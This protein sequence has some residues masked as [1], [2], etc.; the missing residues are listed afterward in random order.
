MPWPGTYDATFP[1]FPYQDNVEYILGSYAN[2]WV[3]A[4]QALETGIGYGS[5]ASSTNPLY[6]TTFNETYSTI[7]ARIV[8]LEQPLANY[9]TTVVPVIDTAAGDIVD[10]GATRSAG[11]TG[12]TAD[13]G[14][15]HRGV[16]S[17]NGRQGAITVGTA[18]VSTPFTAAG[19]IVVGTGVGT[20][21]LLPIGSP[22][23]VLTVGG[24]DPSG[25]QWGASVWNSGDLRFTSSVVVGSG[26]LY[27]D[28]AAVSRASFGNLLA[29]TTISFAATGSGSTL[30]GVSP[31][32][33]ALLAIGMRIE[34]PGLGTSVTI[35][36]VTSVVTLSSPPS[37]GAGT[38]VAFPYGNGN[39]T[40][41]FNVIDMRGRTPVG[42][43]GPGG[44]TQPY[45]AMGAVGGEQ[46]HSLTA[47]ENGPHNHGVADPGHAHVSNAAAGVPPTAYQTVYT[48]PLA[49]TN[50]IGSSSQPGNVNVTFN[51]GNTTITAVTNISINFSGSGSGH[52]T[53]Q[54]FNT[55]LWVV[56]T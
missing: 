15:G 28:G 35:T 13:A 50:Q 5:G 36:G 22:G 32:I 49:A 29:A 24:A 30:T 21:E 27:A 33:L 14:H 46:N 45:F 40:S 1:G 54:P 31:S 53:M 38:F 47:G 26:W 52:N 56:K 3:A 7:T 18:D 37:P 6:S 8:N 48:D 20:G 42:T 44:N 55:G 19:Q 11:S 10:V 51:A 23:T 34:G 17:Y 12:K 39:G 9:S 25:L 43:N 4:F 41:T 16:T 2:A